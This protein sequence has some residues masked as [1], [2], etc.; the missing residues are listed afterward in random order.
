MSI[1]HI[2]ILFE[3][4]H[5]ICCP[6]NRISKT[7]RLLENNKL[8]FINDKNK[9]VSTMSL[10]NYISQVGMLDSNIIIPLTMLK[11]VL[12]IINENNN[13]QISLKNIIYEFKKGICYKQEMYFFRFNLHWI[14][15]LSIQFP[16]MNIISNI[17][18]ME[19]ILTDMPIFIRLIFF[20]N[21]YGNSKVILGTDIRYYDVFVTIYNN[22]NIFLFGCSVNVFNFLTYKKGGYIEG[23]MGKVKQ[24]FGSEWIRYQNG[25]NNFGYYIDINVRKRN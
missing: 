4:L 16:Q 13:N 12:Y 17:Y 11:K 5:T 3:I 24:S 1:L 2:L 14:C 9:I 25:H 23:G 21:S 18:N 8:P 20:M 6:Y 22:N 19:V 10:F 7:R 15:N